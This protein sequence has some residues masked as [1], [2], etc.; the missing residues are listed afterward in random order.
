MPTRR[1]RPRTARCASSNLPI[2]SPFAREVRW[3]WPSQST[4]LAPGVL[5]NTT[6]ATLI[7]KGLPHSRGS[8]GV[9]YHLDKWRLSAS[10]SYY[11]SVTG[12]GFPFPDLVRGVFYWRALGGPNQPIQ[13]LH[14]RSSTT[15]A[16]AN[17][18][19]K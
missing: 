14:Y 4:L 16:S 17:V 3:R 9:S 7:E 1:R 6:Q 8:V 13:E 15:F 11:G 18:P 2:P 5:F 19:G 12:N 10:N